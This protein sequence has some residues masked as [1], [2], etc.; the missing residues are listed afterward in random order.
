MPLH[1][2]AAVGDNFDMTTKQ[3]KYEQ[4]ADRLAKAVDI[5]K[6]VLDETT[7]ID[8]T[9]KKRLLEFGVETKHNAL[10]PQ[11]QFKKIASLKYLVSD[12]FTFWQ[13][14]SGIYVDKFWDRIFESQLGFIRKDVFHDV[15]K[16]KKI[17]NIH[18]FDCITDSIVV[19]QQTGRLTA[20]QV[21]DLK[22]YLGEFEKRKVV[23]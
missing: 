12:Y 22:R 11:P 23:K 16:R 21:V 1:L 4:E 19:H 15:L 7:D 9:L 17:K 13:E 6:T 10:F 3:S 18:E 14:A 8:S 2:Y 5:A 20:D